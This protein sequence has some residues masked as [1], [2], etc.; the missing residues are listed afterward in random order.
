[1]Q[2]DNNSVI[3]VNTKKRK[4]ELEPESKVGSNSDTNLSIEIKSLDDTS[5]TSC[6]SII[7]NNNNN[8]SNPNIELKHVYFEPK[9]CSDIKLIYDGT[10]FHTHKYMLIKYC[11]YFSDSE[12]LKDPETDT[13]IIPD[14]YIL[15]FNKL[16]ILAEQFHKW[17]DILNLNI[18]ITWQNFMDDNDSPKF[19]ENSIIHLNHYFD[20]PIFQSQ[21][22]DELINYITRT[23]KDFQ[24][25]KDLIKAKEYKLT[26]Y[27]KVLV[28]TIARNIKYYRK[29]TTIYEGYCAANEYK[30][31]QKHFN[32][33]IYEMLI[34]EL[35][36]LI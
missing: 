14:L 9:Y 26:R 27:L 28:R 31:W 16:K 7:N 23:P 13:I 34:D 32:H 30:I 19:K 29:D 10:C 1:M 2:D 15:V 11:K 21:I 33:E 20:C 36:N 3:I 8:P 18:K 17:L 12:L 25:T 5:T 4:L 22:E 35:C 6:S 24:L